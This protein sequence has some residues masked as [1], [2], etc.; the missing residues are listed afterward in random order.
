MS[1]FL[2]AQ[3]QDSQSLGSGFSASIDMPLLL[4]I[5][6]AAMAL[7]LAPVA[8]GLLIFVQARCKLRTRRNAFGFLV[9][10]CL[11][12]AGLVFGMTLLWWA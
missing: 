12:L 1:P 6:R 5:P 11:M 3:D 4:Q 10:L 7:V 8:D 9:A 2:C